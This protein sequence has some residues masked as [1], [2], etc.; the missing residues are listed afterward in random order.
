VCEEDGMLG[1]FFFTLCVL[2]RE[3]NG[4]LGV[5]FFNLCVLVRNAGLFFL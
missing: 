1:A 3:E 5:F 4:M 2:V